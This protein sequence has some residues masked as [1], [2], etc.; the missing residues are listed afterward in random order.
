MKLS[1]IIPG[2]KIR[3]LEDVTFAKGNSYDPIFGQWES[4]SKGTVLQVSRVYI[5]KSGW[6]DSSLT[7]K[8]VEGPDVMRASL[9]KY[10][11]LRS[12]YEELIKACKNILVDLD[13]HCADFYVETWIDTK[14]VREYHTGS[15][16]KF[17]NTLRARN[18]RSQLKETISRYQKIIDGLKSSKVSEVIRILIKDIQNWEVEIF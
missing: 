3:L 18:H 15:Y 4:L 8:I 14:F 11:Y 7:F 13:S 12:Y 9:A 5:R 17:I 1:F 10:D 2:D 16:E 6:F